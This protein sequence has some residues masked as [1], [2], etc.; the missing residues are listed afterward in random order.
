MLCLLFLPLWKP[1]LQQTKI[2][3]QVIFASDFAMFFVKQNAQGQV[4]SAV[5][6][7]KQ[8]MALKNAGVQLLH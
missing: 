5:L 4:T 6:T 1:V 2:I 8:V 3:P 7:S